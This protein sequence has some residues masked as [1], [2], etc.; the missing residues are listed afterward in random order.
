MVK[1][2]CLRFSIH[3]GRL[4]CSLFMGDQCKRSSLPVYTVDKLVKTKNTNKYPPD[5]PS[6]VVGKRASDVNEYTCEFQWTPVLDKIRMNPMR[7]F[8]ERWYNGEL[9]NER[10][11]YRGKKMPNYSI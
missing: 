5:S 8:N 4:V 2:V 7:V 1:T 3:N 10:F 11:P 6:R 9:V